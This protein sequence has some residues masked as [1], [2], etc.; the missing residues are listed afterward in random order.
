ML[1]KKA[2][3]KLGIK[4]MIEFLIAVGA[5]VVLALLLFNIFSPSFDRD[6]KTAESY[7]KM[8]KGE[9]LRADSGNTGVFSIL[10]LSDKDTDF[11]LVY[12]DKKVTVNNVD[13]KNEK[14]KISFFSMGKHENHICVCYREYEESETF[15]PSCL[16]L[17]YPVNLYGWD[18]WIRWSGD[19]L[20]IIRVSDE[21]IIKQI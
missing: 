3:T 4:E 7:L 11:Y 19:K 17:D 9:I 12:F 10:N 2:G 16:D 15:C 5:V 20:N 8:F 13:A 1:N 18:S 14:E 21:Y 6:K